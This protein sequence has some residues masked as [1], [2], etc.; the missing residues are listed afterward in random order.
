MEP[1]SMEMVQQQVVVFK[2]VRLLVAKHVQES[3]VIMEMLVEKGVS[4]SDH[5]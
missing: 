4:Q 1:L 3:Q 5:L 2:P